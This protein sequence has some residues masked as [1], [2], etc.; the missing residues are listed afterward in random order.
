VR[1]LFEDVVLDKRSNA[2]SMEIFRRLGLAE[3]IRAADP[4]ALE[5]PLPRQPPPRTYPHTP[6]AKVERPSN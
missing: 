3:K 5:T 2:R 4:R 6:S 1:F